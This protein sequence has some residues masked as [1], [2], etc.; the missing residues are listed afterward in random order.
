LWALVVKKRSFIQQNVPL[1]E[2]KKKTTIKNHSILCELQKINQPYQN[3][4][5]KSIQIKWN[6]KQIPILTIQDLDY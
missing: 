3:H 6:K 1:I 4:I 2:K 5:N